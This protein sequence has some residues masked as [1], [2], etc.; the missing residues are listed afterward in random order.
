VR[1]NRAEERTEKNAEIRRGTRIWTIKNVT[2]VA[3]FGALMFL[4]AGRLDWT[5]G[6]VFAAV[7]AVN[8]VVMLAVIGRRSPS[9]LAERSGLQPN[10]KPW[11]PPLA[12][13]TAYGPLL[14]TLAAGLDL[15]FGWTRQPA[16][17]VSLAMLA[18]VLAGWA[19][20]DWA[21]VSNRFFSATVRIQAERG[22]AVVSTGPYRVV[23]HPGYAGAIVAC[24]ALPLMLGS[25]CGFV[26][27]AL[28]LA[29]VVAR[30]ALEDRTLRGEL[31]GYEDYCRMTRYR[32]VP[33]IW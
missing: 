7:M 13:M 5:M 20:V 22:H 18:P 15:R 19:L 11:D 4:A 29:A 1:R 14:V 2:S 32:L 17:S 6:W 26:P 12:V 23:R 10:T 28:F 21:M 27:F 33:G 31:P 3:V 25:V 9:L 30:T 24:A 16:L 8:V